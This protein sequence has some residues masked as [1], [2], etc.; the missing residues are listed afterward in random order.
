MIFDELSKKKS[1]DLLLQ[2]NLIEYQQCKDADVSVLDFI[3]NTAAYHCS[4]EALNT[5]SIA[6]LV[7]PNWIDNNHVTTNQ[8]IQ[9]CWMSNNPYC[10]RSVNIAFPHGPILA[11]LDQ[12]VDSVT[13]LDSSTQ[14]GYDT[15]IKS[16]PS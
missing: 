14:P 6:L 9:V 12:V 16:D 3:D 15:I 5:R 2:Q 10:F 13:D 1:T 11:Y 4:L 7:Y 8:D